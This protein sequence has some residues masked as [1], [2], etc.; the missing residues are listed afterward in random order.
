MKLEPKV[1][2]WGRMF[3]DT[4]VKPASDK[5]VECLISTSLSMEELKKLWNKLGLGSIKFDAGFNNLFIVFCSE[6]DIVR[7]GGA[8]R[9]E[10]APGV[11]SAGKN[12]K[13]SF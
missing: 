11:R 10:N 9:Y 5:I 6:K 13:I 7:L 3:D 4:F 12:R 8:I 1:E 2:F